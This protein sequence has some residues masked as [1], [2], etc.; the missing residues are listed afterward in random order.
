MPSYK[1]NSCRVCLA[2]IEYVTGIKDPYWRHA[3]VNDLSMPHAAEPPAMTVKE[4]QKLDKL[5][6][7]LGSVRSGAKKT[8]HGF[9]RE[10]VSVYLYELS[11]ALKELS[12]SVDEPL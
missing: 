11:G 2:A 7:G 12:T 5:I 9:S 4:L 10:V 3:Q 1:L 6:E 8:K